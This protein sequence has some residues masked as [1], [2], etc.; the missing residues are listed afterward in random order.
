MESKIQ[1]GYFGCSYMLVK[2][3]KWLLYKIPK[4][5]HVTKLDSWLYM[6]LFEMYKKVWDNFR[7]H[8]TPISP[9]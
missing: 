4:L 3:Q 5:G 8:R 1:F 6:F 9:F 2:F 7:L